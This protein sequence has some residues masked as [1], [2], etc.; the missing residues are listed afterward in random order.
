MYIIFCIFIGGFMKVY[1]NKVENLSPVYD[2][3][4][5]EIKNLFCGDCYLTNFVKKDNVIYHIKNKKNKFLLNEIVGEL[6]SEHFKLDTVKS[7]LYKMEQNNYCILTKLFT[8][9]DNKYGDIFEIFPDFYAEYNNL[10]ILKYLFRIK[11]SEGKEVYI[12]KKNSSIIALK[13]KKMI[14][15]DLITNT[16]DRQSYNFMFKVTKNKVDLM[17]LFDYEFSFKDGSTN[18]NVISFDIFEPYMIDY[19]REDE[20]FQKV[21]HSAMDLN[22]KKII[23]KLQQEYPIKLSMDEKWDYQDIVKDNQKMIHK[24][25]LLK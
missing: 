10:E 13:L 15:R 2:L 14:I 19:F 16:T 9:K 21:L 3:N 25:R 23:K 12:S 4:D 20:V 18:G 7:K 8:N 11:N 6:V 17:P 1:D 24:L 22:M 5:E